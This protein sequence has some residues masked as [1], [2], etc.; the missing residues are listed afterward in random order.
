MQTNTHL[1]NLEEE[2]PSF[3]YANK[4]PE[5]MEKFTHVFLVME[6]VESD[7]KKL[8]SSNPPVPL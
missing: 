8:I 3:D 1:Q 4:Y 6:L 7:M 2:G 5:E